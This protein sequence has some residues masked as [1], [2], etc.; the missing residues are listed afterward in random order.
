MF[1]VIVHCNQNETGYQ[2]IRSPSMPCWGAPGWK[3]TL[4]GIYAAS[5]VKLTDKMAEIRINVKFSVQEQSN[6]RV[7]CK[8]V[9][10]F[11]VFQPRIWF[12]ECWNKLVMLFWKLFRPRICQLP[13]GCQTGVWGY[14]SSSLA[15]NSEIWNG[16]LI[17][18]QND[19]FCGFNMICPTESM[20]FGTALLLVMWL[21]RVGR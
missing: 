6:R 8:P 7:F 13:H 11:I 18:G 19:I 16:I 20:A 5:L 21:Y 4:S 17:L 10:N 12:R 1:S 14:C 2:T 3:Q 15:L 9:S